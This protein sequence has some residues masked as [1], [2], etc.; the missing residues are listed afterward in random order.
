VDKRQIPALVIEQRERLGMNQEEYGKLYGVGI[1]SVCR[2][3]SCGRWTG[4]NKNPPSP[5]NGD[6]RM[7]PVFGETGDGEI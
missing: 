4:W 6:W 1:A 2:W 5:P 3:E 7:T